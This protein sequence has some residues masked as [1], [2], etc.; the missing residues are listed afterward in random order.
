[1]QTEQTSDG[2]GRETN[3][4]V[5]CINAEVISSQVDTF[6]DLPQ[7]Q[8]FPIS[9]E[10]NFVWR[11]SHLAL[12]ETE[13]MLLVHASRMVDVSIHFTHVVKVPVRDLLA[14]R[15]LLVFVEQRVKVEFAFQV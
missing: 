13:K 15:D 5:Q 3:M 4:H 12:D 8:M 10:N 14:V 9:E 11:L 7:G 2:T 1:M 6:K